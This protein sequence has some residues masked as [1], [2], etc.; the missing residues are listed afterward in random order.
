MLT[1]AHTGSPK[2]LTHGREISDLPHL[3]KILFLCKGLVRN[4]PGQHVVCSSDFRKPCSKTL[5]SLDMQILDYLSLSL[6]LYSGSS[7]SSCGPVL[8]RGKREDS[9]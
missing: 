1:S 8:H 4:P 9:N 7:V 3:A 6:T 2:K 5:G